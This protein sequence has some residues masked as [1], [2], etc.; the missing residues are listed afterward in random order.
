METLI[1]KGEYKNKKCVCCGT[2]D[3][4]LKYIFSKGKSR[5]KHRRFKGFL[6]E[7]CFIDVIKSFNVGNKGEQH[8]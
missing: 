6:C 2:D 5:E 8:E 3:K 1:L 4:N 7:N